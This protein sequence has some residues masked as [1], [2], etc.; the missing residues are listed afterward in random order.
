MT[1]LLGTKNPSVPAGN[2]SGAERRA[3]RTAAFQVFTK[4]EIRNTAFFA[5]DAQGT[6]NQKPPSGTPCTPPGRCFPARC[7]AAW[8]GYGAVWAAW[9]PRAAASLFTIVHHCSRLFGIVQQKILRLSQC[10]LSVLTGNAAGKVFTNHETRDKNHGLYAFHQTR[11][12]AFFSNHGLFPR[13]QTA[14][15]RRR[16]VRRLQG[17]MYE[18]V[19]KRVER[20]FSESREKNND[21]FRIPI[22]FKIRNSPLFFGIR[23]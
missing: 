3:A 10:P 15:A 2:K 13:R 7:G 22:R 23:R 5:V 16:Q 19:R 18:A 11:D 4:H 17:G 14:D 1:P 12:T 8:G 6:H 20:G 21:F 9:A